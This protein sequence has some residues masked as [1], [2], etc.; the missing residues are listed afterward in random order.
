MVIS[1]P[2][3]FHGGGGAG[4]RIGREGAP[5]RFWSTRDVLCLDLGGAAWNLLSFFGEDPCALQT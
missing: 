3:G 5:G 2:C 1:Q 4:S